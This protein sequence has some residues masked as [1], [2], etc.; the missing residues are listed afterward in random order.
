MES[1]FHKIAQGKID[2]EVH[3]EFI[4]FSKGVFEKRF[5]IEGKKQKDKWSI[6]TGAEFANF[7]VRACI[8]QVNGPIAIRGIIVSTFDIR[9]DLPFP[10][11]NIKQFMGIKR[12]IIN[13]EIEP[14]SLI[15]LMDKYPKAFYALS[16]STSAFEL[17]IKQKMP[18][19]AKPA[20]A[21]DKESSVNFCSLKTSDMNLISSLF[22]DVPEFKEISISHTINISSIILPHGEKDPMQIREKA[23]RKGTIIRH[24]KFDG[25]EIKKEMPFEA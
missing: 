22:F 24:V 9:S 16:F 19:N 5:L 2:S 21:G 25:K 13:T 20:A 4:K 10:I 11:E 12:L 17:K 6:K 3:R 1:L 23:I 7:F 14:S 8:S 15:S 18:K